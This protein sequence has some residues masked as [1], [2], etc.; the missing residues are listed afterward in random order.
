LKTGES[1]YRIS[2]TQD[3]ASVD[4]G[5]AETARFFR[6]RRASRTVQYRGVCPKLF[7]AI[8]LQETDVPY[9]QPL[10]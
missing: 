9:C 7:A 6:N 4:A 5:E 2:A 8:L 10:F 3:K 1:P